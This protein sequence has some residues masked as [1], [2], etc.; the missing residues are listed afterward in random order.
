M[1]YIKRP[2]IEAADGV[3]ASVTQQVVEIIDRVRREGL[4]AVADYTARFD[5]YQGPLIVDPA[6]IADSRHRLNPDL[7]QAVETAAANIRTFHSLQKR[8]FENRQW[9]LG[10]GVRA[11]MRFVP[12]ENVAVYVPAGRYPLIST[13]MM[14]VIPA[15]VA[16]VSRI[17]VM[18]P[19]SGEQGVNAAI[20]GVAGLLGVEEVWA[21]GG[22]QAIA[23]ASTGAR[24]VSPLDM[25][26]GPGNAYVTEAKRLVY[27]RIGVDGIAGPSEVLIVADQ[28]ADPVHIALDLLAQ[29][30]HDPMSVCHLFCT[31]EK[32]AEKVLHTL[33]KLLAAHPMRTVPESAWKQRGAALVGTLEE[34]AAYANRSA[35]EHLELLVENP[36]ALLQRCNS[37][38][39]AFLGPHTTVAFGD[40]A[41]GT[42]HILP[43]AGAAR[44]SG[45]VWVGTYLKALTHQIFESSAPLEMAQSAVIIAENEGLSAHAAAM[46]ARMR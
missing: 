20:L 5:G 35:P 28:T 41:T 45:G 8:M 19:P 38:G 21:V 33:K 26:V 32:L 4:S 27:G 1:H 11:G 22:A 13:T 23:L 16:G 39:S 9:D 12:V 17:V 2:V 6:L 29:A 42:N 31:A 36:K 30:E 37:Y 7:R 40:F 3:P 10:G 25:V 44:F 43:T 15:Q 24:G 34:A 14:G 18:S 46:K